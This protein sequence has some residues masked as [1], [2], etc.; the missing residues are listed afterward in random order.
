MEDTRHRG[1]GT[2][3]NIYPEVYQALVGGM[4][5]EIDRLNKAGKFR[6]REPFYWQLH[7]EIRHSQVISEGNRRSLGYAIE[8]LKQLNLEGKPDSALEHELIDEHAALNAFD[9]LFEKREELLNVESA[10]GDAEDAKLAEIVENAKRI[11][12]AAPVNPGLSAEVFEQLRARF[13]KSG[14]QFPFA[15]LEDGELK[16]LYR[17]LERAQHGQRNLF[18]LE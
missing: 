5:D 7:E 3:K 6:E 14:R 1:E 4:S 17:K 12:R 11:L 13:D 16:E 9:D 15:D 18:G 10:G 2:P 8:R